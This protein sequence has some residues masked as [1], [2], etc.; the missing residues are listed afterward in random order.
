MSGG[1]YDEPAGGGMDRAPCAELRFEA[2]LEAPDPDVV[3]SLKSGDVLNLVLEV[4]PPMVVKAMDRQGR[5]AGAVTP[6]HGRFLECLRD[7]VAF[8][9]VVTSIDGGAIWLQVQAAP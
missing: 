9:G 1:H 2:N 5:E 3:G 8:V 7:G 6:P 4:G